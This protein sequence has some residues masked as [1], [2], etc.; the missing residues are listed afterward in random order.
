M[1]SVFL[2]RGKRM[3]LLTTA[4]YINGKLIPGLAVLLNAGLL[5][6]MIQ[7]IMQAQAEEDSFASAG[8]YI[9]KYLLLMALTTSL[10]SLTGAISKYYI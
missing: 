7:K 9:K 6:R 1:E 10:I 5:A 4:G 8:K 3:I 2:K